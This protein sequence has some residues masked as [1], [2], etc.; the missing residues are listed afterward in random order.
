MKCEGLLKASCTACL[1]QVY[2]AFCVAGNE[3]N[4]KN[5]KT[6]FTVN[7]PHICLV[8]NILYFPFSPLKNQE[9]KIKHLMRCRTWNPETQRLNSIGQTSLQSWANQ[10]I[11]IISTP[12]LKP[13][14]SLFRIGDRKM[15]RSYTPTLL[16]WHLS[17][18][19]SVNMLHKL[20]LRYVFSPLDDCT[21]HLSIISKRQ[22]V[23]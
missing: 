20:R 3:N 14:H 1:Q 15:G 18:H 8:E 19:L 22:E 12:Y 23:G 4:Q 5:H 9:V 10:I 17:I 21:I 6:E 2:I 7:C 13:Q 16:N 11:A